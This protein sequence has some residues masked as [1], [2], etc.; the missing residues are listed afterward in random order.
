MR[1]GAG[2]DVDRLGLG[3]HSGACVW[4]PGRLRWI[5][6]LSPIDANLVQK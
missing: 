1:H 5:G 2:A 4:R 3:R 6:F